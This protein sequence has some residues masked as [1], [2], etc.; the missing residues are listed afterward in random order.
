MHSDF[1]NSS[2][3]PKASIFYSRYLSLNDVR[4][5]Q[6]ENL[7]L[8]RCA[9]LQWLTDK[10]KAIIMKRNALRRKDE[11]FETPLKA[12]NSQRKNSS[13][14]E[15]KRDGDEVEIQ[16]FDSE[17]QETRCTVEKMKRE[18]NERQLEDIWC[19]CSKENIVNYCNSPRTS[20]R[21]SHGSKKMKNIMGT[22][23]EELPTETRCERCHLEI[24]DESRKKEKIIELWMQF[25]G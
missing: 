7:P 19:H 11:N 8:V 20:N 14:E 5:E 16:D 24:R 18:E 6:E 9:S 10:D 23:N 2:D 22:L 13:R 3:V 21:K 4:G 12:L 17:E 25:F 1:Q 15:K